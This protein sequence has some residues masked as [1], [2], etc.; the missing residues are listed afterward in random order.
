MNN[1]PKTCIYR[2][3]III[4]KICSDHIM[5]EKYSDH[6][7]IENIYKDHIMIERK[8]EEKK[9]IDR[10]TGVISGVRSTN[11]KV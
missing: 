5:I 9:E 4:E 6:I 1:I 8:I 2:D 7:M 11:L 10:Y 3:H